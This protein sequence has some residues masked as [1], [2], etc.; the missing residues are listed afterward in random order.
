[1]FATER[2][3]PCETA[4]HPS[5]PLGGGF[6]QL[7]DV[8]D[9]LQQSA[10]AW[11]HGQREH[12]M[13]CAE[14]HVIEASGNLQSAVEAVRCRGLEARHILVVFEVQADFFGGIRLIVR[15]RIGRWRGTYGVAL[16]R[17]FVPSPFKKRRRRNL[18]RLDCP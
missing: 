10:C 5:E 17:L 7:N 11:I 9:P 13:V 15:P 6:A 2:S 14:V 4:V 1:M 8:A 3:R 18:T 12:K 16:R